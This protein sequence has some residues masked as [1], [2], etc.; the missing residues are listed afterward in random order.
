MGLTCDPEA[1]R[2]N[3]MSRPVWGILPLWAIVLGACQPVAEP[4]SGSGATPADDTAVVAPADGL[5]LAADLPRDGPDTCHARDDTIASQ[6][7]LPAPDGSPSRWFRIPC[8]AETDPDFVSALQRALSARG[9]YGGAVN[10]EVDPAT[11][12][13]IANYQRSL[14]LRS[15]VLSTAAARTLGLVIWEPGASVWD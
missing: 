13:A 6:A 7:R 14:G 9:F 10:G 1:H 15:G 8:D 5:L 12:A 3:G 4:A 2:G 11:R